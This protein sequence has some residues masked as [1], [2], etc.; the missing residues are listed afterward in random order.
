MS[1]ARNKQIMQELYAALA[2]GDGA[3]FAAAMAEDFTWIMTG[4]TAW[5]RVYR[6]KDEVRRELLAPLY[7]KFAGAYT[8]TAQRFIAEDDLVVV[9]CRGN[10]TT[11][12]GEAYNN[13]YCL[14]FRLE[15][16]K[17]KEMTEYLDTA[18]VERVLGA[19]GA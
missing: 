2:H 9:E 16:G 17:L 13:T 7:A 6:G 14:V 5:S 15:G 19:P 8:N 3:P 18:L 4:E 10:V 12:K 1:A 11:T